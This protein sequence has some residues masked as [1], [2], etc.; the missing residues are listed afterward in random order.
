V[1][2]VI[3]FL[4]VAACLLFAGC[5]TPRL[6]PEMEYAL[7]MTNCPIHG[8]RLIEREE[9]ITLTDG[10]TEKRRLKECAACVRACLEEIEPRADVIRFR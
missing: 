2:V 6:E 7:E 8:T 4:T 3:R 1:K 9:V 10:E 5:V